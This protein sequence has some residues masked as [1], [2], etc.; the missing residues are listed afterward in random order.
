MFVIDET[1]EQENEFWAPVTLNKP[2]GVGFDTHVIRLKF[3]ELSRNEV[4]EFMERGGDEAELME[5]VVV[6]WKDVGDEG[7]K[8]I[9]FA[10]ER[11]SKQLNKY[12]FRNA[13]VKTYFERLSGA[14]DPKA[15]RQ[16]N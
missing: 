10:T 9:P 13:C 15:R 5:R 16:K 8:A 1:E 3:V 6:D 7:G 4:D 12:W 11:F 2:S 14:K